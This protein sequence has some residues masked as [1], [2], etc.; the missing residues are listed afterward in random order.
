MSDEDLNKAQNTAYRIW[1]GDDEWVQ[2]LGQ[3]VLRF[4]SLEYVTFW[5][6]HMFA[7]DDTAKD[8]ARGQELRVRTERCKVFV[9]TALKKKNPKLSSAWTNFLVKTQQ[10]ALDRNAVLHNP[11]QLD[12]CT[13]RQGNFSFDQHITPMRKD[14]IPP[15]KLD[16]VKKQV[17][18]LIELSDESLELRR[19]TLP[20]LSKV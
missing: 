8:E 6:I 19:Q 9:S 7:P 16:T 17:E 4:T 11:L 14:G 12:I 18:R 13:D 20:Y 3:Y 2:T 5:L 10:A 1:Q 15:I